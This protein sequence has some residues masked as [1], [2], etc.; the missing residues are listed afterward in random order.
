MDPCGL[1]ASLARLALVAW[2]W[3]VGVL[4]RLKVPFPLPTCPPYS[5][6]FI[7]LIY[8][9]THTQLSNAAIA[10]HKRLSVQLA[11]VRSSQRPVAASTAGAV[12]A[13]RPC[14]TVRV[15][16]RLAY[17]FFLACSEYAPVTCSRL[18]HMRLA[19]ALHAIIGTGIGGRTGQDPKVRMWVFV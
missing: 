3:L 19:D 17:R 15:C 14:G 1:W 10:N 11:S 18:R 4:G 5:A 9:T 8:Q 12:L 13:V 16:P 2:V 7:A 6:C